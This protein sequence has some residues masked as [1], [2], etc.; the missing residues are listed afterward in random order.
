MLNDM[1]KTTHLFSSIE[2]R[3]EVKQKTKT[4]LHLYLLLLI[5]VFTAFS[6]IS[7]HIASLFLPQKSRPTSNF[8]SYYVRLPRKLR[9]AIFFYL[10]FRLFP[11]LHSSSNNNFTFSMTFLKWPSSLSND[12]LLSSPSSEMILYLDYSMLFNKSDIQAYSQALIIISLICVPLVC[13]AVMI[14][15]MSN[16]IIQYTVFLLIKIF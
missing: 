6:P 8:C 11:P 13:H 10:I 12:L 15:I 16:S 5:M 9:H 4:E 14:L 2:L 3:N 1:R 7:L